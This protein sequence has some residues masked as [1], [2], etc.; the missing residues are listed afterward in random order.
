MFRELAFVVWM[1]LVIQPLHKQICI[2]K[3]GISDKHQGL[4][5]IFSQIFFRTKPL[6]ECAFHSIL[7]DKPTYLGDTIFSLYI[8]LNLSRAPYCKNFEEESKYFQSSLLIADW[9]PLVSISGRFCGR[10]SRI[11]CFMQKRH[12]YSFAMFLA[13]I[14]TINFYI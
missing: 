9:H 13:I 8:Y 12:I 5:E 4:C 7:C 14:N 3:A 10:R 11:F 6:I 2:D 1:V